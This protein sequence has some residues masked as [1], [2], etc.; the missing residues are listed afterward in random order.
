MDNLLYLFV[1]KSGRKLLPSLA[2][3]IRGE[4]WAGFWECLALKFVPELEFGIA[5]YQ[6]IKLMAAWGSSGS[7]SNLATGVA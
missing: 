7:V 6:T 4:L 2:M 3:K 1:V 5:S